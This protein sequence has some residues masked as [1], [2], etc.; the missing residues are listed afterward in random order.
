MRIDSVM[1]FLEGLNGTLRPT[2]NLVF[3]LLLITL[4][5]VVL[6]IAETV[7]NEV[8]LTPKLLLYIQIFAWFVILPELI[9]LITN[10]W[11]VLRPRQ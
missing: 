11:R 3:K 5:P 4:I 10:A 7:N 9:S 6:S 8:Y 1:E 2:M